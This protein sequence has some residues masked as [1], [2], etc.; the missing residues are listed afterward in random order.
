MLYHLRDITTYWSKIANFFYTRPAF[1]AP[2]GGDPV[3]VS[4]IRLICVKLEWFRYRVVR[5]YDTMLN[6]FNRIPERNRQ[7]DGRT[8]RQNCYINIARQCA[9]A[10]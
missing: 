6:R 4:P 10:R 5:N 1:S 9:D 3:G 2:A 7:T 8:D